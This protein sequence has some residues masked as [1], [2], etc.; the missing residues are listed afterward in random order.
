MG[1]LLS[2]AQGS[3]EEPRFIALEYKGSDTAPVVLL[4][5]GVTF[6]TGGI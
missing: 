4:G 2:V 6:D 5:L 3:G 1:A